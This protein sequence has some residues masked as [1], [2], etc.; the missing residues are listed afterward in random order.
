LK[1][2]RDATRIIF[3]ILSIC[4]GGASKTR[5]VYQVNLNSLLAAKYVALLLRR[6]LVFRSIDSDE[7]LLFA[8]TEK[9]ERLLWVLAEAEKELGGSASSLLEELPEIII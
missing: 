2:R 6:G 1:P 8:T 3:E 7:A 9:G 5:I 4:K